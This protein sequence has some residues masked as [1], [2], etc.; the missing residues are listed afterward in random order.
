VQKALFFIP[1]KSII[2]FHRQDQDIIRRHH[3]L[4]SLQQQHIPA[5]VERKGGGV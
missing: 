5:A 2:F 3:Y 4:Q 1:I